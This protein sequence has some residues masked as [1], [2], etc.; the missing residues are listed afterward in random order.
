MSNPKRE[1]IARKSLLL[2]ALP[3]E[4]TDALIAKSGSRKVGRGET[5]FLHGER[6]SAIYIV[7]EGWVKLYRIAPNGNEAVVAVMTQGQ[8]FGE[9]VALQRLPFPVSSEA[10]T[11]AEIMSIETSHFRAAIQEHPEM[12]L[13]VLGGAYAHLHRLVTEIEDLK[14]RTG[15][16]RVAEFLLDLCNVDEGGCMVTLPYDKVL[17]AGRLGMKPESLSRAFAKLRSVGVRV[18]KAHAVIEKVEALRAYAEEDPANA[19]SKAL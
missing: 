11:D 17:I 16:Q 9:A 2:S 8:S 14:A 1:A 3:P 12:A 19:W 7:L 5:I 13:S 18:Q 10:V 6:A 4:M 15:A